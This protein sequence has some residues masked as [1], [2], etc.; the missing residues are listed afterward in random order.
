MNG[1]WKKLRPFFF[2]GP[3]NMAPE[4]D[5]FTQAVEET[6]SLAMRLDLEVVKEDITE[7]LES[8]NQELTVDEL[9]EIQEENAVEE[10]EESESVPAAEQMT[11]A[12]LIEGLDFIEHGMRILEDM[13]CNEERVSTT[14][15]GIKRLVCPYEE[16]LREKK[17]LCLVK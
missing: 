4:T 8:H 10:S 12:K 14:I 9:I 7:L 1:V 3:S 16:I 15:Q 6:L 11:I 2:N 13:D 5:G 17:N